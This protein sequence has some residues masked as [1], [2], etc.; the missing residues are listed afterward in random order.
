VQRRANARFPALL[1]ERRPFTPVLV[2]RPLTSSSASSDMVSAIPTSGH[3]PQSL[4][5]ARLDGLWM[6]LTQFSTWRSVQNALPHTGCQSDGG[7]E[8]ESQ[9][10]LFVALRRNG[11]VLWRKRP[12]LVTCWL[13]AGR[14]G[15]DGG[16]QEGFGVGVRV[17]NEGSVPGPRAKILAPRRRQLEP[18][19]A[20]PKFDDVAGDGTEFRMIEYGRLHR[21]GGV[22]CGE[23]LQ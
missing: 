14:V 19:G 13:G 7:R 21:R 20:V 10:K 15:T 8:L 16:P 9:W 23:R 18:S 1:Y 3:H 6:T 2:T 17:R 22:Q 4:L 11:Q 5:F 12:R